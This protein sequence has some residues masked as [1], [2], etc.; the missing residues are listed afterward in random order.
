M[1][2]CLC[3]W[4]HAPIFTTICLKFTLIYIP[5]CSCVNYIC[6]HFNSSVW[7]FC[8]KWLTVWGRVKILWLQR[9]TCEMR[10]IS[11]RMHPSLCPLL[12]ASVLHLL[13]HG[14]MDELHGCSACSLFFGCP[15]VLLLVDELLLPRRAF[16]SAFIDFPK[17]LVA[18]VNGPAVGVSVTVLSLF[19]L[20]YATDRVSSPLRCPFRL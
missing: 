14:Y 6:I 7:H 18:V 4:R 1:F 17:P 8:P 19:D 2:G 20:V 11:P 13:C 15:C 3:P 9:Y 16:V 12:Q 10:G 5:M